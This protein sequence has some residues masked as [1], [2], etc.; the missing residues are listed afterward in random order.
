VHG[1]DLVTLAVMGGRRKP[2]EAA[3][4]QEPDAKQ[5]LNEKLLAKIIAA[6]EVE[7][8][9]TPEERAAAEATIAEGKRILRAV[10]WF[11]VATWF[12]DPKSWLPPQPKAIELKPVELLTR[13]VESLPPREVVI[14]D[15]RRHVE[16]RQTG[17][18]ARGTDDLVG[19]RPYLK[20]DYVAA[21]KLH[22]AGKMTV[23]GIMRRRDGLSTRRAHRIYKQLKREAVVYDDGVPLPGAGYRWDPDKRDDDPPGYRL[24]RA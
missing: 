19:G 11:R 10:T 24:I 3:A 8:P 4:S 6:R 5:G 12:L 2:D 7:P 9:L 23:E 14:V 18:A 22:A 21:G 15:D 1:S 16:A 20:A 17:Q 13:R